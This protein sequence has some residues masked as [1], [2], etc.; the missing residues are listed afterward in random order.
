VAK[1]FWSVGIVHSPSPKRYPLV[2][3]IHSFKNYPLRSHCFELR[4]RHFF[5]R[6]KRE[7]ASR[8]HSLVCHAHCC[9]AIRKQ[10]GSRLTNA[11]VPRPRHIPLGDPPPH[12]SAYNT[13]SRLPRAGL[14]QDFKTIITP[15]FT[16]CGKRPTATWRNPLVNCLP[17][18]KSP[19]S[20]LVR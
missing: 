17:S 18:K 10:A 19:M 20:E 11:T 15:C 7:H 1:K 4:W 3:S 6:L 14:N 2:L 12:L 5:N 13:G 16:L 8:R 9:I